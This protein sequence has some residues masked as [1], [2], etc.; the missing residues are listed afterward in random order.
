MYKKNESSCLHERG[1]FLIHINVRIVMVM[2]ISYGSTTD[3]GF[4]WL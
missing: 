1:D 3:S 2:E 4:I